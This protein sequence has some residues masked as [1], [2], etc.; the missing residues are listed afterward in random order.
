MNVHLNTLLVSLLFVSP[1]IMASSQSSTAQGSDQSRQSSAPEARYRILIRKGERKLY[2]YVWEGGKERLAKTYQIA[3]GNNPTG[4]KRRQGDGATPEGDYYITHKN[5]RSNFYLSLGVSY[6]N[7]VDADNGL[8]AGLIT[9][10]EH[11]AIIDAIRVKAKP[12]Q[13]TRLGGDIFIHGGGTGKLFGL[14]RDWTLGC[15]ALE[16]DEIKEL[17]ETVPV[18]T[19]V[20]IVP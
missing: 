8:K 16:N 18:K 3:L 17:F 2:L 5:A 19:P 20:K 12:P 15:V 4:S 7:I 10:A 6:P 13:T 11:Q 9:K 14:V 1:M